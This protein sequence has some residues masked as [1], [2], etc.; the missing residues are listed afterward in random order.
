[1]KSTDWKKDYGCWLLEVTISPTGEFSFFLC[2]KLGGSQVRRKKDRGDDSTKNGS[3]AF[4]NEDPSPS[5][6]IAHR[7][8]SNNSGSKQSASLR[9]NT[10][11]REED[12]EIT[13]PNAPE[14]EAGYE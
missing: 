10:V 8:H 3:Y 12:C 7:F 6:K 5:R 13:N 14:R 1:M 11:A 4:Q 2:E 9:V